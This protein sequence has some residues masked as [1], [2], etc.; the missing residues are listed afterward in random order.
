MTEITHPLSNANVAQCMAERDAEIVRLQV[1]V[2]RL[3]EVLKRALE[4]IA[5]KRVPRQNIAGLIRAAIKLNA[6][7]V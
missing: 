6:H 3:H 1:E 4:N 7:A 2:C 5:N